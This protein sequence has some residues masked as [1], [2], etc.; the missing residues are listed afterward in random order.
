MDWM[1]LKSGSDVRGMAL[2][3][4]AV[5]TSAVAQALGSAFIGMLRA[6]TGKEAQDLTVSIGR[7]S[8]VTGPELL[9]AAARGMALAGARVLDFGLCTTPAMYMSIL[10]EGFQT[11]GAVM[12]TAS[13]HPYQ[14]NGL[15]F[16]KDT[17]GLS[18][19]E[20]KQLLIEAQSLCTQASGSKGSALQKPF[21]PTYEEILKDRIRK[22]LNTKVS[23]PLL[24]LHV[25]VDAG[26]GA[27]GFYAGMLESLG[28][29]VAGS[30]FLTPDG[31]FP[32]HIPNP[33]NEQAMESLA[34]AVKRAQAD[35]GVIFDA[36]CDRAA[37]V[38]DT[39]REIN[40][41]RLIALISAIL[42]DKTPGLTIVT[43]SVTSS[44]LAQFITEWGGVHYRFKRG[45]RNVIDEAIRLNKSGIDCPLA[46]ETSGHAALRENHFLDDGMYLVTILIVEAMKRKQA[47]KTLGSLIAELREPVESAEIRLKITDPDFRAAGKAAIQQVLDH[48]SAMEGWHVAP[49]NREGVRINFD[50]NGGFQNG[51]FLLRLS[52]HD[53]VLPLN[54]E[55]DV[56]GGMQHMLASLMDALCS[57]PGIDLTPL[58]EKLNAL[59]S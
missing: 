17:G 26:N 57:V 4:G 14:M 28:A 54:V 38:D 24:G 35:L 31:M 3:E 11:D 51:W 48:A 40:R 33:E 42:L 20:I 47:G 59:K 30:Q 46:I 25:V 9:G 41:N 45:Y 16:F 23:K 56:P 1:A 19:D 2:G 7:D 43:D 34:A 49:D 55:S 22:G 10:T 18:E 6:H 13:H 8:R 58:R 15:K 21:L 53:P 5:L 37:I 39:G 32:N 50:L 27:G 36:D 29:Q 12:V 44:G 52:V